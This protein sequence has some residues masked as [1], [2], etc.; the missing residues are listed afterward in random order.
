MHQA[1]ET[2]PRRRRRIL[3]VVLIAVMLAASACGN[4]DDD[5][6]DAADGAGDTATTAVDTSAPDG[7]AAAGGGPIVMDNIA[8]MPSQIEVSVG[9][10]VEAVNEDG[11]AHTWT[12]DDDRWDS[13]N[14]SPG[15]RF[16]HEFT[17]A[18][19]FEFH[20]QIHPQMTGAV[21]VTD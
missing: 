9:T 13:G 12:S 19:T 10:S 6:S 5:A 20:C 21:T 18:G 8:F 2:T 15:E 14:L 16:S 3:G 17:E 1:D 4:G 11:V 7:G